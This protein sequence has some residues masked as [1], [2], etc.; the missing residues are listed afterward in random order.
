M[1]KKKKKERQQ[2]YGSGLSRT[3]YV[4]T[5]GIDLS[6]AKQMWTIHYQ[7][8]LTPSAPSFYCGISAARKKR[9]MKNGMA[10]T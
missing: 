6:N 1:T 3:G 5:L 10:R 8:F 4:C 7:A 9:G 2:I